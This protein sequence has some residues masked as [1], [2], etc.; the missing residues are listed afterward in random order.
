MFQADTKNQYM[1]PT[2][3]ENHGGFS[4]SRPKKSRENRTNVQKCDQ[5]KRPVEKYHYVLS[6]TDSPSN[7]GNPFR[8]CSTQCLAKWSAELLEEEEE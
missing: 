1:R 6:W 8:F 2:A 5:C 7:M 4:T 3:T